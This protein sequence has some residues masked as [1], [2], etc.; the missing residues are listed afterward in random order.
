MDEQ[1][2][3]DRRIERR[4]GGQ[5]VVAGDLE[6]DVGVSCFRRPPPREPHR[7]LLPVDPDNRARRADRLGDEERDVSRA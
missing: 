4:I 3:P 5:G 6:R 7:A 1:E 2:P